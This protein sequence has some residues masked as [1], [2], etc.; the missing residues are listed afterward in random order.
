MVEAAVSPSGRCAGELVASY[1]A[2]PVPN[3]AMKTGRSMD[4]GP[5][6]DELVPRGGSWSGLLF[7][8]PTIQLAPQLTWTFTFDFDDVGRTYGSTPVSL[9]VDWVPLPRCSWRNM[10]GQAASASVFAEPVESSAYFFEHYRYDA[11]E[12]QVVEQRRHELRVVATVRG[13]VDGLGIEAFQADEWLAFEGIAVQLTPVPPTT[14]VAAH[15]LEHFTDIGGLVGCRTA[16]GF[17][18]GVRE[19]G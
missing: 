4:D 19:V 3:P 6:V 14:A 7:D 8:N 9:S 5:S 1:R 16:G 12:L 18:F 2:S 17:R 15:R 13:E 11:V 10:V